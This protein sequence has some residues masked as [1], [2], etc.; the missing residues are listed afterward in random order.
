MTRRA[1]GI[2][3]LTASL[4]A[5]S[6]ARAF[7]RSTVDGESDVYLFWRHR[8][9]LLR[10]AYGSSDEI[11]PGA[12]QA[13]V[14]RSIATWNAAALGCPSDFLLVDEG[15]PSGLAT[16][17]TG[18]APDGENRI[19]W[20]ESG[21]P[22][23]VDPATLALTTSVFRRST[24]QLI[25]ADVDVNAVDH[26]W[27]VQDGPGAADV[28][29]TLTHELGHLLGLAHVSDPEA[30]MYGSSE[31]G[32]TLKRTLAEDDIAGLCYVYPEGMLTPGAPIPMG[33]PLSSGCAIG[34]PGRTRS[35]TGCSLG[36]A[37]LG[38]IL[39]RRRR[40]PRR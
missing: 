39:L 28:E 15:A 24:G 3:L 4:T 20:R 14:G 33:E 38:L 7:E 19:V 5:P 22:A 13:A 37:A 26:A 8:V 30:T 12:V 27:T 6:A 40:E 34:S 16:N 35:S 2:L 21:W 23:E 10:P 32:E 18:G 1:L 36:L 31:T 11:D 9:V 29:N 25:D 17:L